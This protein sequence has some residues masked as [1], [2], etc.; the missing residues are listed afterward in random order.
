M[1]YL[2]G[3]GYSYSHLLVV[4]LA[5][6]INSTNQ[7]EKGENSMKNNKVRLIV[8]GGLIISAV[9]IALIS[10]QFK[11]PPVEDVDIPP[12]NG[13]VSDVVVEKPEDDIKVPPIDIPDKEPETTSGDDEGTEQTIQPD[14]VKPKPTEDELK[15]KDQNPN[16]DKVDNTEIPEE[17][18]T[19]PTKPP[20][21]PTPPPVEPSNP[22]GGLPGFDNVPDKG[23]SENIYIEGDGDINKPVGTMD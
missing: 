6:K 12:I 13:E 10:G 1:Q 5:C 20:V 7:T 21:E 23:P 15:D 2:V 18:L 22:S 19:N 8:V 14:P 9:L 3:I 4:L 11:T 17:E 16:G